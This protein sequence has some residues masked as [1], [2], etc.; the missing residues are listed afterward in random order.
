MSVEA[1][2]SREALFFSSQSRS[3]L[4]ATGDVHRH[5]ATFILIPD[6]CPLIPGLLPPH[7]LLAIRPPFL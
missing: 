3:N 7:F 2:D 1:I 4:K 6:S 5:A